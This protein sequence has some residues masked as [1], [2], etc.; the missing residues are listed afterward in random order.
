MNVIAGN[1]VRHLP[2]LVWDWDYL[3]KIDDS[4]FTDSFSK[5]I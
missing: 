1:T 4:Y 5:A 3:L 2:A